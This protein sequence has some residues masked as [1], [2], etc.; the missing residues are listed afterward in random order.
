[1]RISPGGRLGPY[2]VVGRI[3]AGGMGE[4][5]RA[6]DVRLEREVAIKVLP[7]ELAANAQ[8]R[9]RFEREAKAVAQLAHPNICSL[10]D[11][12]DGYFVMEL[13][14][15][16][17]LASRIARGPL[18]PRD[19][20]QLGAQIADALDQAH[21]RGIVHRDLKPENV[22]LTQS[23]AKLLDFGLAW[24]VESTALQR[25]LTESG[26]VV[27]TVQYMAPEQV[28]AGP[29][30]HRADIF[31]LGALLYEA[32]TGR[33]AFGGG[34]TASIFAAIL[35]SEPLPVAE[36]R[37]EAP[38]ALEHVIVRC[39]RKL[40][41]ERWQSARDIAEELRW[42][43][44]GSAPAPR[45]PALKG[46][47]PRTVAALALILVLLVAI[48]AGMFAAS[49]M[50]RDHDLPA[51]ATVIE[52]PP[53][54]DFRNFNISPDGETVGVLGIWQGDPHIW[55][56]RLGNFAFERLPQTNGATSFVFSPDGRSVAFIAGKKL[57]MLRLGEHEASAI[58]SVVPALGWPLWTPQNTIV[59][60]QPAGPLLAV[61]ARPGA[62]PRA[63]TVLGP[64]ETLHLE[65]D[66]SEDGE[67]LFFNVALQDVRDPRNGLYVQR[68][69]EKAKH[70]VV[71]APPNSY[72]SIG[73]W[74]V[75]YDQN[76]PAKMVYRRFDRTQ[77]RLAEAQQTLSAG[78][79]TGGWLI[80]PNGTLFMTDPFAR[81]V[82]ALIDRA[83]DAKVVGDAPGR[84]PRVS[85]D[86]K[87]VAYSGDPPAANGIWTLDLMRGTRSKV[88]DCRRARFAVWAADGR[89]VF[90][91][92]AGNAGFDIYT[93]SAD[94]TGDEE[95]VVSTPLDDTP[96]GVSSD[97]KFLLFSSG[98]ATPGRDVFILPLER[99]AKPRSLIAT[100]ADERL[101]VFSPDGSLVAWASN[102][103]GRTEVYVSALD[104]DVERVQVSVEGG[105]E[106]RWRRDGREL[107]IMLPSR[108]VA[109]VELRVGAG[110]IEVGPPRPLFSVDVGASPT[111][112]VL[113]DG[114]TFVVARGGAVNTTRLHVKTGMLPRE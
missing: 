31:A 107:F 79:P 18:P 15:G 78:R 75:T 17:T 9:V 114:Q 37:P 80:A 74:L 106:P 70:F 68:R 113:P 4:V 53:D 33:A 98:K 6:R 104:G 40:P 10:F 81:P 38:P 12:G 105:S 95:L 87:R 56:R 94:G 77:L 41:E 42:I 5:W 16:D 64:D 34:T 52:I 109:S 54:I 72:D 111:Y 97:G 27:G 89:R 61:E 58:C 8:F 14:D 101:A 28:Q 49:R 1:M 60:E 48:G 69:G 11:I 39:L 100:P 73:G 86:G 63:L 22:M 62:V 21:R 93:R 99:G 76:D 102:E 24:S 59:L 103:A 82:V 2:E 45:V 44:Q 71:A 84:H 46:R 112:D 90:Y 30:D 36:L 96:S 19:V 26:M 13:L 50:R 66:M 85:P 35:G 23:G 55:I 3:G 83:G 32:L 91:S 51:L 92:C 108:K 67:L 29:V 7:A 25:R 88:T 110:G 65:P 20:A 47:A 43:A 57:W